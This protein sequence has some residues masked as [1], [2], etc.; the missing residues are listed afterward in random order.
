MKITFRPL[1]EKDIVWR[2]KW[3]SDPEVTRFLG[4]LV[5]QGVDLDFHQKWFD[6]YFKDGKK[7]IFMIVVDERP[8]GQVGLLDIN[9]ADKNAALYI[10]IG[11]KDMHRQGIGS[12]AMEFIIDYGF[13]K[14]DLHRIWLQVHAQNTAAIK[15]YEKFNFKKEGVLKESVYHENHGRFSDEIIM[16]LINKGF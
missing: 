8:V 14:L 7:E 6:S 9:L 15:L 2:R 16:A 3:L 12:K 10:M 4:T 11:E 13:K 1:A 5:R